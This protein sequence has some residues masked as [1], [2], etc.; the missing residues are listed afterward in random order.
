MATDFIMPRM[1]GQQQQ[2]PYYAPQQQQRQQYRAQQPSFQPSQITTAQPS[3]ASQYNSPVSPLSTSGNI[4][5]S[6]HKGYISRQPRPLF[7]PAVLR[8]TEFPSKEPP[9][10]PSPREDDETS[11][12]TLRPNSSFMNLG[13]LTPFGRLSRRSTGDSAKCLDGNWNLD[14]FPEPTGAPTRLHW[15]V[16]F[17]PTP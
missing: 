8:P 3:P 13:G 12:Q 15:K 14:Q 10:E 17:P 11:E 7:V 4:S 9:P 6:T 1:P 2:A 16:N 5:P